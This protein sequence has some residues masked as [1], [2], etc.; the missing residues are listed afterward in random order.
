MFDILNIIP[1]SCRS[2]FFTHP[3]LLNLSRNLE[4]VKR[5]GGVDCNSLSP[6]QST[7]FCYVISFKKIYENKFPLLKRE[8][9]FA[10]H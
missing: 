1:V 7:H 4:I 5:D 3:S 8:R 2:M 10:K 9:H 6:P